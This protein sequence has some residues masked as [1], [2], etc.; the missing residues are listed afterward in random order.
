MKIF[1]PLVT[2]V[3]SLLL[4]VCHPP[5]ASGTDITPPASIQKLIFIHHST[6]GH[7]LADPNEDN[8]HGGL[9][10]ALKN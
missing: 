8:P 1:F 9:G 10:T 5:I 4:A 3:F 2:I 7:W 6:G